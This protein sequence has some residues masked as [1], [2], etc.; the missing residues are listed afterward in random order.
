M[1]AIL[2]Q[3]FA[4]VAPATAVHSVKGTA[5]VLLTVDLSAVHTEPPLVGSGGADRVTGDEA[6]ARS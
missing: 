1:V 2:L 4:A 5:A 6:P 3:S